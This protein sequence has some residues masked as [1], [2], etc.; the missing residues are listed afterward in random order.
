MTEVVGRRACFSVPV[1]CKKLPQDIKCMV[2]YCGMKSFYT[3]E[4]LKTAG[5]QGFGL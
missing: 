4:E 5:N 3:E 2:I 1:F